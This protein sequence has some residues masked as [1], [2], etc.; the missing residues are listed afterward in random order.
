MKAPRRRASV[1]KFYKKETA[2][3]QFANAVFDI[4]GKSPRR[5]KVKKQVRAGTI[6]A[7][8]KMLHRPICLASAL[9]AKKVAESRASISTGAQQIHLDNIAK[10]LWQLHAKLNLQRTS[11]S[12][13]RGHAKV[14]AATVISK[15][16]KELEELDKL[17]GTNV[18]PF[19]LSIAQEAKI[20]ETLYAQFDI[21]CRS[22]SKLWR[23]IKTAASG[24]V[25]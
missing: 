24:L 2:L 1:S 18:A 4:Y 23:E 6:K 8:S 20:P 22:M 21:P 19:A 7:I 12:S 14:F 9:K 17:V 13:I 16:G 5:M 25:K 11:Y 10:Q 15:A 3:T